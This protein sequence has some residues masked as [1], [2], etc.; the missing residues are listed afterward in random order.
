MWCF[1]AWFPIG[2]VL[3]AT[4]RYYKTHWYT[5]FH[6]H[7]ILGLL[8]TFITIW[9][10]FEMYSYAKWSPSM[11]VHSVLGL[12]ALILIVITGGSGIATSSMMM[13]YNGDKPW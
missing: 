8:V 9:T 12:I 2:F 10:C 13:F 1:V 11:G 5:M 7:N 3:I 6:L 4:Q